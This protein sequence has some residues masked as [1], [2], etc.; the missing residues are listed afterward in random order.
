MLSGIICCPICK[1][2]NFRIVQTLDVRRIVE[3]VNDSL[4]FV[5]PMTSKSEIAKIYGPDNFKNYG[6][7]M[8]N[9]EAHLQYF[10]KKVDQI[11]KRA[12]KKG[13]VLDIG[14]ATGFFLEMAQKKGW[15]AVGTDISDFALRYCRKRG[16]EVKKGIISELKFKEKFDVVVSFQTIEHEQNPLE[17]LVSIYKTLK[18]KGLLVITTP[19]HNVWSRKLL[20]RSWFGYKHHEHL[21][22]LNKKSLKIMLEKSGFSWTEFFK[23]DQRV[24]KVGLYLKRINLYYPNPLVK[25]ITNVVNRV[26]GNFSVV[27]FA[28]PWGDMII[29]ARK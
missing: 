6:P 1:K 18:P 24:F 13:R 20:G 11:E 12:G 26:I 23:D 27:P 8:E 5:N 7:Y 28:D 29:F 10:G 3:C 14:C 2:K 16:L 4:V 25:K 17:H 22:F 15:K 19:D 9:R 21:F